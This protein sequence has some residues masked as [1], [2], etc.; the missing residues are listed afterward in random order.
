M[1]SK[2][3]SLLDKLLGSPLS[4]RTINTIFENYQMGE[5]L[6]KDEVVDQSGLDLYQIHLF[7]HYYLNRGGSPKINGF[8]LEE[9][10]DALI[11]S[12]EKEIKLIQYQHNLQSLIN[13]MIRKYNY[14]IFTIQDDF[15]NLL[16]QF[17]YDNA[18]VEERFDGLLNFYQNL[19]KEAPKVSDEDNNLF[20]NS[21]SLDEMIRRNREIKIKLMEYKSEPTQKS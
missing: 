5:T 1:K 20:E 16:D 9:T 6:F 12:S 19:K 11:N 3:T 2:S 13:L 14:N 17:F 21:Y 4:E 15:Y 18:S 10:K 7:F 8:S